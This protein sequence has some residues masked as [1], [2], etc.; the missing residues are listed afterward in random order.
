MKFGDRVRVVRGEHEGRIGT[1]T[2][3]AAR[4]AAVDAILKPSETRTRL[5]AKLNVPVGYH[6]VQLD[7]VPSRPP[8]VGRTDSLEILNEDF[9]VRA[10]DT[11]P[12]RR[13]PLLDYLDV[14]EVETKRINHRSPQTII[15]PSAVTLAL[16]AKIHE[17]FLLLRLFTT[18]E[19]RD[20]KWHSDAREL[21]LKFATIEVP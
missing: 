2:D 4:R 8:L 1:V 14:L 19:P 21:I 12:V 16:I 11:G 20:A 9:L 6:A 15:L 10:E 7:P 13:V 5:L 3:V 18:D 17:A